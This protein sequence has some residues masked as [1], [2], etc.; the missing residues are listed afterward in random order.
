MAFLFPPFLHSNHTET[1]SFRSTSSACSP[2]TVWSGFRARAILAFRFT[3]PRSA[4]QDTIQQ[5]HAQYSRAGLPREL[6]LSETRKLEYRFHVRRTSAPL[7]F[8]FGAFGSFSLRHLMQLLNALP[9]FFLLNRDSPLTF[10]TDAM[11]RP[12]TRRIPRRHQHLFLNGDFFYFRF[13]RFPAGDLRIDSIFLMSENQPDNPP[14]QLGT[15]SSP[16][17]Q[18]RPCSRPRFTLSYTIT[19][20]FLYIFVVSLSF[21]IP[22]LVQKRAYCAPVF[23]A[24]E[25]LGF[26]IFEIWPPP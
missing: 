20:N 8:A 9:S 10:F 26:L 22:L 16:S 18:S 25:N 6:L 21:F 15:T 17:A 23:A 3:R 7:P 19:M 24:P 4:V 13:A 1:D 14:D 5:L 11:A 12:F 2:T